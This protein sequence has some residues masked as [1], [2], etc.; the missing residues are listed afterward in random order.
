[1]P[2]I[3]KDHIGQGPTSMRGARR[4][5]PASTVARNRLVRLLFQELRLSCS[6][7]AR[8]R[9]ETLHEGR[10]SDGQPASAELQALWE[11]LHD[12]E[13]AA[14]YGGPSDFVVRLRSGA[15][16]LVGRANA[17]RRIL[18]QRQA[19]NPVAH[20]PRPTAQK[21][22]GRGGETPPRPPSDDQAAALR[23]RSGP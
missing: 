15:V 13:R 4:D 3:H 18:R 10:A 6:T 7:I 9:W 14:G 11:A 12:Q 19:G 22:N 1:M 5:A 16:D 21:D 8:L 20:R 2:G 17:V 23:T